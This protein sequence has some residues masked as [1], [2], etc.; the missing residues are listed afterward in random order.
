MLECMVCTSNELRHSIKSAVVVGEVRKGG[1]T[2]GRSAHQHIP[3]ASKER[4]RWKRTL[5]DHPPARKAPLNHS[6]MRPAIRPLFLG[7]TSLLTHH[8][9]GSLCPL[10]IRRDQRRPVMESKLLL[11]GY[12][13]ARD[14][15]GKKQ[16]PWICC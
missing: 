4:R 13:D 11:Q 14:G 2:Q 10:R 6:P 8:W 5:E 15:V 12:D 7:A 9:Y 1:L 3:D 16:R